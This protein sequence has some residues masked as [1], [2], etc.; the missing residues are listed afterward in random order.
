MKKAK[1]FERKFPPIEDNG[2]LPSIIERLSRTPSRIEEII[3]NT[4]VDILQLKSENKWSIKEEVGHLGDLEPLWLGRVY[5][6]INRTEE[7]RAA[8][9]TNQ[10]TNIANHNTSDIKILARDF[11]SQR[12]QLVSKLRNLNNEV[13]LHFSLHP[14]LKTPMRIIDLAFFVAEHDD[15]HLATIQELNIN[16]TDKFEICT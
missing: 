11:R 2:L 15:H 6:F 1:W 4:N 8:D 14:R 9:L 7:L 5:D 10:K 3:N 16:T 12:E 13:L